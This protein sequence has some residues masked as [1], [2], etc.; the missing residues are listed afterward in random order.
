M[1]HLHIP[2]PDTV[3][4][5]DDDAGRV[6]LPNSTATPDT[7]DVFDIPNVNPMLCKRSQSYRYINLPPLQLSSPDSIQTQHTN[8]KLQA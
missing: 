7:T 5:A 8:P 4:M 3:S 1:L 2:A 6:C